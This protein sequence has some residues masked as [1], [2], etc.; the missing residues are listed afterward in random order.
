MKPEISP[1][2]K[3]PRHEMPTRPAGK[4]Q[5]AALRRGGLAIA[6]LGSMFAAALPILL[7]AATAPLAA[8]ESPVEESGVI[9]VDVNMVQMN[10]AVTDKKGNYISGLR[11]QQFEIV[12]DG[13]PQLTAIFEEGN[14]P[15]QKLREV[16]VAKP[17]S[18][19]L[20]RNEPVNTAT[21]P[22]P[23]EYQEQV[24]VSKL[25]TNVFILFD[26]S[27][28]MYR[29]FPSVQDSMVNFVRSLDPLDRVAFYSYSRDFYRA[30]TLTADRSRVLSGMH[31]V[32]AGDEAA[33]YSAMLLS[34]KDA[35]KYSGRKV[36][37]VFS[38][39]PDKGSMISPEEVGELA[40]SAGVPIYMVGTG[41][42]KLDP[43][44]TAVFQAL[45]ESTGGKAYFPATREEEE[46]VFEAIR[47]DLAHLYTLSY[48]P[49]P[50]PNSGW[51]T[52][53]VTLKGDGVKNL[54]I[55]TRE[56]YRPKLPGASEDQMAPPAE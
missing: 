51:R 37:V 4:R 48:Y 25:G 35:G 30:V 45:S 23:P 53:T 17:A 22:P 38:H 42:A 5:K 24:E 33:L 15:P 13:I 16:R 41:G 8:Q 44:S 34:L 55:R 27:D 19:A 14:Q 9:H 49:L 28:Y 1:V 54:D 39:G 31:N 50:N 2:I 11:P 40:Q 20:P 43:L 56:G 46:K 10:V 6:G 36:L 21:P 7:V 12:E 3:M 29:E 26:T 47:E 18:S 52:I 32:A